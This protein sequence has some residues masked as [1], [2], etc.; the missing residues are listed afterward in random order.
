MT[1]N[2]DKLLKQ[3]Q[4]NEGFLVFTFG[5]TIGQPYVPVEVTEA[6]LKAKQDALLEKRIRSSHK[7]VAW[8]FGVSST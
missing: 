8:V 6:T 3:H 1:N 5:L 4:R 7:R 2:V